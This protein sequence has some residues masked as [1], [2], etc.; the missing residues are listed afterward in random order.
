MGVSKITSCTQNASLKDKL[1]TS[2]FGTTYNQETQ[3][4]KSSDATFRKSMPLISK[5]RY[6]LKYS[7]DWIIIYNISKQEIK[8]TLLWTVTSQQNFLYFGELYA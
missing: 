5:Y 7:E 8:E 1:W 3:P 2:I 4:S 6:T